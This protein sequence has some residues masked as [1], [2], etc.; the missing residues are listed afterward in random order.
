MAIP[1]K[2]GGIKKEAQGIT[3]HS[4]RSIGQTSHAV[5]GKN[6]LRSA[7]NLALQR[8]VRGEDVRSAFSLT[9]APLATTRDG[10]TTFHAPVVPL[11]LSKVIRAHEAVHR[12]QFSNTGSIPSSRAE[13]EEEAG[14]GARA[15]LSGRD[16]PVEHAA[17][18]GEVY[19]AD[20]LWYRRASG[21]SSGMEAIGS[22]LEEVARRV[23][24]EQSDIYIFSD[25]I[26]T[27][28]VVGQIL[29]QARAFRNQVDEFIRASPDDEPMLPQLRNDLAELDRS[30]QALASIQPE[31]I[32]TAEMLGRGFSGGVM[33]AAGSF[34][35]FLRLG[36]WDSWGQLFFDGSEERVSEAQ[37]GM[38]NIMVS[39][40][41]QG[42]GGAISSG[43]SDWYNRYTE[44]LEN[45][46]YTSASE[47]FGAT[48]F[49]IY[50]VG[51]GLV[52]AGQGLQGLSRAAR[53]FRAAGN[54]APWRAA[55]RMAASEAI[56]FRGIGLYSGRGLLGTR[57]GL[58]TVASGAPRVRVIRFISSERD[59]VAKVMRESPRLGEGE[60]PRST[61][62][63]I[64]AHR[65][66]S[67]G[68]PYQSAY[69]Y[70]DAETMVVSNPEGFSGSEGSPYYVVLEIPLDEGLVDVNRMVAASRGVNPAEVPELSA[71]RYGLRLPDELRPTDLSIARPTSLFAPPYENLPPELRAWTGANIDIPEGSPAVSALEGVPYLEWEQVLL[72]SDLRPYVVA[73]R[74][75]PTFS[76]TRAP[77]NLTTSPGSIYHPALNPEALS[78]L[79]RGSPEGLAGSTA[80]VEWLMGIS[81]LEPGTIPLSSSE[82]LAGE[83]FVYFG[84]TAPEFLF[85]SGSFGPAI[86]GL[87]APEYRPSATREITNRDVAMY[88]AWIE[89]ASGQPLPRDISR[90]LAPPVIRGAPP[91]PAAMNS[92]MEAMS[93]SA[94]H[95]SGRGNRIT[96][97]RTAPNLI[98]L[99]VHVGTPESVVPAIQTIISQWGR[100]GRDIEA[101]IAIVIDHPV[102]SGWSASETI[103][104]VALPRNFHLRIAG[105]HEELLY[106]R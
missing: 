39:V 8:F 69:P 43:A 99:E 81:R 17:R 62:D 30:I 61:F 79:A 101:G 104:R 52:S 71:S 22:V 37:E 93:T 97:L 85:P 72:A 78:G 55:I 83:R 95:L 29:G 7:G 32:G 3:N 92:A 13:L 36:L 73:I 86:A 33:G 5:Q 4:P 11:S 53:M 27:H 103:G 6:I 12:A 89:Q 31:P 34:L 98:T 51:R 84:G 82:I 41:E 66:A 59:L 75:N 18:P 35:G 96:G 50:F 48:G 100:D 65:R 21:F 74:P 91:L 54:P 28:P 77:I 88:L 47:Q 38:Y 49:D 44:A 87:S 2:T 57:Y 26:F 9:A 20:A 25:R 80:Y 19:A 90:L 15:L 105:A 45:E 16:F 40:E 46:Y 63:T 76:G 64:E 102:P 24:E 60:Q 10:V 68:G 14:R 1:Q 106:T 94:A 67:V 23:R 70:A 58:P 42:L 56:S